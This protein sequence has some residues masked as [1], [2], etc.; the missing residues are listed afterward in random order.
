MVLISG[1]TVLDKQYYG[2]GSF[3]Q[4]TYSTIFYCE[5][6]LLIC[7]R[8]QLVGP[9]AGPSIFVLSPPNKGVVYRLEIY[10]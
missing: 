8:Y 3:F 9:F 2:Q 10:Q 6:K 4:C 7:Q 1:Y 5:S